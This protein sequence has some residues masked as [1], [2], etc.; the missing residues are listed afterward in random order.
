VP[1]CN[2]LEVDHSLPIKVRTPSNVARPSAHLII[3]GALVAGVQGF[4]GAG[5]NSHA[6]KIKVVSVNWL[7][8]WL[9]RHASP[10]LLYL[11]R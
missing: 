8:L 6:A 11:I 1:R 3:L 4:L 7:T 5:I 9:D 2:R 10:S